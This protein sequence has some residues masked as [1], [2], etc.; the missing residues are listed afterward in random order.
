MRTH[1]FVPELVDIISEKAVYL[2]MSFEYDDGSFTLE[3]CAT[4]QRGLIPVTVEPFQYIKV[5]Q[6]KGSLG[7]FWGAFQ[8]TSES[9]SAPVM[10]PPEEGSLESYWDTLIN[11][12]NCE[13]PR[14][15]HGMPEWYQ[16]E[17]DENGLSG[18]LGENVQTPE[19]MLEMG[20][21]PGQP[22][23][24]RIYPPH[25]YKSSWEYDEWD[26]EWDWDVICVLP[27]EPAVVLERWSSWLE[28]L[29]EQDR[30]YQENVAELNELR[31]SDRSRMY[32]VKSY[33]DRGTPKEKVTVS[34]CTKHTFM[35]GNPIELPPL[36]VS[37]T[38]DGPE[39]V[40]ERAA[41]MLRALL[42]KLEP[43]ARLSLTDIL[44]LRI[45]TT[46]KW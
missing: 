39:I 28:L 16:C 15:E 35:I 23:L 14:V 29:A 10:E 19:W 32:L 41:P 25:C 37:V 5:S 33:R 13:L 17:I 18:I 6:S 11:G 27:L 12:T 38:L 34:L 7:S 9:E 22:L 46:G 21:A 30:E 43:P 3:S 36:I 26:V 2:W 8:I 20:I 40:V 24:L 1:Q 31:H 45:S 42:R 44:G 4:E